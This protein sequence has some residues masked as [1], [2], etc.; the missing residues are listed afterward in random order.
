MKTLRFTNNIHNTESVEVP[1]HGPMIV[2][3]TV[4]RGLKW[5]DLQIGEELF[6]CGPTEES[7]PAVMARVFDVKV[8][9]FK[10]LLHYNKMLELH[11]DPA[12]KTYPGL[13]RAMKTCYDGFLQ[14]EIV[15]LVFYQI[16]EI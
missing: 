5:A 10:D 2:S 14:H 8:M 11:H 7:A 12:C 1:G 15:T 9:I 3:F 16:Q 6:I 4:R 13:H